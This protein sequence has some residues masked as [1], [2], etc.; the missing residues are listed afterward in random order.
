MSICECINFEVSHSKVCSEPFESI[1]VVKK[2]DRLAHYECHV[3][4]FRLPFP[5]LPVFALLCLLALSFCSAT[6]A[7]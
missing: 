2:K 3:R 1:Y 5:C 6:Y 4:P 7:R